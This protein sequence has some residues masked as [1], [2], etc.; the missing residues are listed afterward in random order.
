MLL[1]EKD[2]KHTMEIWLN[3]IVYADAQ[4]DTLFSGNYTMNFPWFLWLKS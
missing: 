2:Q 1:K 4:M 3:S